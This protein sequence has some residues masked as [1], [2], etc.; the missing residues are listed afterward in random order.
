MLQIGKLK[1]R[2]SLILAPMAGITDLPFRLLCREFGCELAFVEMLNVRSVSYKSKKTKQ[3]LSTV[4]RDSPLGIQLLGF[5]DKFIIKALDILKS[6]KFD[7]LDFNAACPAKKVTKRG[8]GAALLRQPKK[9]QAIL[10]ILVKNSTS[11]VTVKIRAGWDEHSVNAREVALISEDAGVD[12]IFVH[13][14]T[15]IQEYRGPVNYEAIRQVKKAV[16]VPVIASG[17]I[18]NAVLAKKMLDETGCDGLAVARGAL[19][20]PWIFKEISRFLKDGAIEP[21]PSEK[22]IIDTIVEHL[23]SCIDFYGERGGAVLFRKFFAWYTKGFSGSRKLREK[24]CRAKTK[25]EMSGIIE[26]LS[27]L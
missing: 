10:R 11:P 5:E 15:K 25:K 20:N 3:M 14:R 13:G 9:L 4:K 19:G 21:R 1:L 16:K 6:H 18:F 24:C 23:N 12:A 8:E 17:D 26:E 7:I 22:E 27:K 2:Q